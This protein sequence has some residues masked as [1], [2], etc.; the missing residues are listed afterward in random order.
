MSTLKFTLDP[1]GFPMM[2]VNAINAYMHWMPVSKIQFEHFLCATPDSHFDEN[3]YDQIISLNPRVTPGSI[4]PDNYWQALLSGV[5]PSEV[6]RF[7]RWCGDDY[8]V[9]TLDDWFGAYTALKAL[10]PES[11]EVINDMGNLRDRVRTLLTRLDAA[12]STALLRVGYERTLADQMLMRLG[13][14]EWVE[15]HEQHYQWGGMGETD[16]RF[17][18]SLFTPDHGQ[19]S[20]PN[21]PDTDRLHYYGFRL[22][23]R[24]A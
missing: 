22:I 2:W 24:D 12:S 17:Q 9:P 7:A 3:W 1:T 10:P 15:C 13:V 19:P 20:I 6:L 4:R 16:S 11:P 14:I 21:N 18:G 23:R 8:R 5:T